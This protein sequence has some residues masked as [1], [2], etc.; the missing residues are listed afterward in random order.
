MNF[1]GTK[2]ASGGLD[3]CVKIWDTKSILDFRKISKNVNHQK[4]ND[5]NCIDTQKTH[6]LNN[7]KKKVT[8]SIN[9]DNFEKFK[10][11]CSMSRHNGAVTCIKFSPNGKYLASGSDDKICLIWEKENKEDYEKEF[12]NLSFGAEH[13]TVRKRLVAHEN[14]IQDIC[15]SPCGSLLITVS[16]DRLIM[17]WNGNTFERIKKYVVHQSMVKGII[18]D[19][20]NKFFATA[21]DDRTVCI[22]RYYK[23]LDDFNKYEFQIETIVANPFKQSPLTSYFRRMSW[24]P[25][26]QYIAVPNAKNG[27]VTCVSI[28]N[29]GSWDTDISLIGHEA[30]CEVCSFSPCLYVS[31]GSESNTIDNANQH[32]FL[33]TAGQDRSIVVWKTQSSRPFLVA[34]NIVDDSI[35]D[36][37]WS[38]EGYFLYFSCL[39]GSITCISFDESELGKV[40]ASEL[41]EIQLQKFGTDSNIVPESVDQLQLEVFSK[42]V[43]ISK[44]LLNI[45]SNTISNEKKTLSTT[46]NNDPV[47][48]ITQKTKKLPFTNKLNKSNQIFTITKSGKKRIPPTLILSK[49]NNFLFQTEKNKI[50]DSKSFKKNLKFSKLT[51]LSKYEI[52]SVV[53]GYKIRNDVFENNNNNKLDLDND[54]FDMEI[55]E[56]K[57]QEK[58]NEISNS[59]SQ[60]KKKSKKSLMK[61]RYPSCF[62]FVSNLSETLFNQLDLNN[63]TNFL[64]SKFLHI[65]ESSLNFSNLKTNYTNYNLP[66][67]NFF[68]T[69]ISRKLKNE[70]LDNQNLNESSSNFIQI[71][72]D[73]N[74]E[75]FKKFKKQTNINDNDIINPT[76]VVVLNN[77][78]CDEFNFILYFPYKIQHTIPIYK[79]HI[80][81]YFVLI[82]FNGIL[83]IVSSSSG[84]F[85]LPN[86]FLGENIISYKQNNDFLLLMT[87]SGLIHT[88]KFIDESPYLIN[89][90]KGVSIAPIINNIDLQGNSLHLEKKKK[91]MLSQLDLFQ[92]GEIENLISN[93]L[94]KDNATDNEKVKKNEFGKKKWDNFNFKTPYLKELEI[95]PDDGSPLIVLESQKIIFNFSIDLMCWVNLFDCS[96]YSLSNKP[97]INN[98]F[99]ECENNI[100]NLLICKILNSSEHETFQNQLNDFLESKKN[101]QNFKIRYSEM[102]EFLKKKK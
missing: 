2:L 60:I 91:K 24:S 90:L 84:R 10:P 44:N 65:N 19:P 17:I 97:E 46:L 80:L 55:N 4:Q 82:S 98:F 61:F 68:N 39:D 54:N 94:N 83:Q 102:V 5:N 56:T 79:N 59:F 76:K 99:N 20:A 28:I 101:F 67:L 15:W 58:Y 3:G 92:N 74:N 9:E 64:F 85:I 73:V 31:S 16:L 12:G 21:S 77:H 52:N 1:D 23:K 62:K 78:N 88:W 42:S 32:T 89:I 87:R 27:P 45:K 53:N 49:S 26:G 18:F 86:F 93:R 70:I 7:K 40:I 33:V 96:H 72:V 25:D 34:Q 51:N 50:S 69:F 66:S 14:D 13:W 29:R 71:T 30:P 81:I 6:D 8:S 100:I 38:P 22:F 48:N 11:L 41:T 43:E 35:T 37:C 63:E 75:T 95:N 36:I 47:N 57:F